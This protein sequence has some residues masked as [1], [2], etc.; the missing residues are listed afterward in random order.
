MTEKWQED[1]LIADEEDEELEEFREINSQKEYIE[2]Y[3]EYLIKRAEKQR[4]YKVKY[5]H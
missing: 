2:K 4:N 1:F 5:A 3:Q